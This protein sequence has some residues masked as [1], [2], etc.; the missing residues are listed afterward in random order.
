MGLPPMTPRRS[1]Q[2]VANSQPAKPPKADAHPGRPILRLPKARVRRVRRKWQI[3][4]KHGRH[5][6]S[7]FV[8]AGGTEDDLTSPRPT[9]T[10]FASLIEA[11][12]QRAIELMKEEL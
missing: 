8:T 2:L 3:G 11:H 6:C 1:S 7:R 9:D 4:Y 5:I 10:D 12:L